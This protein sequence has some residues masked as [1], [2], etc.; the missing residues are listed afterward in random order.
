MSQSWKDIPGYEGL[1]LVNTSGEIKSLEK[2]WI[3]G[4]GNGR[5]HVQAEKCIKPFISKFGYLRV[6]LW[7]AGK[8]KKMHV[9]TV[10]AMTFIP[11]PDKKAQV[12]HKDGNKLNNSIENLEWNTPSENMQHA[13][14]KG[15]H[16]INERTRKAV[17]ARHKGGNN[18]NAKRV[19][20]IVTGCQYDCIKDAA[21]AN[22]ISVWNLYAYLKGRNPN[23]TNLR[24][25][26]IEN[27]KAMYP[28]T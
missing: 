11:N 7:K 2:R 16:V 15:L 26:G 3:T 6:S 21:D 12:N 24:Y 28:A 5:P 23:K 20:D 17:S 22:G 27:K 25:A 19:I 1:Y 14:D 9:H 13:F 10:V 18:T 4:R 8:P